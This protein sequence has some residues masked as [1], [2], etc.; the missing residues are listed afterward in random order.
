MMKKSDIVWG[1]FMMIFVRIIEMIWV[2]MKEKKE[3]RYEEIERKMVEKGNWIKK[4]LDYGVKLWEKK[5]MNK[6]M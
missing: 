2:K 5:K 6:W 1:M 4:K 3:E